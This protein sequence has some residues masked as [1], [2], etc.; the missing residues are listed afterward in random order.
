LIY[1]D[2]WGPAPDSFGRKN[3]YVSFIVDFS[4]FTWIYLIKHRSEVFNI[5]HQFQALVERRFDRKIITLQ[6]DW[7]GEYERLNS[8]FKQIGITHH[9][10]YPHAHQQNGAAERKHRHIVEVGLSLLAQASMPLKYWD[11]AFIAAVYLI[12]RLPTKLLD[13]STP[14]EVL[15]KI[16]PDYQS[17]RIFG[18]YPNLRPFNA[19]KLEYCSIQCVFLGYSNLHKGFKC[20]DINSG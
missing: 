14:L 11:E 2:V 10:T 18:C 13:F 6:S 20:L 4:K 17:M 16:K 9:V 15:E 7:G 3:Y 5:F 1:S 19:R 12:N 8:F